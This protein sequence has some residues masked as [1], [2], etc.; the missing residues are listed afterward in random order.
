MSEFTALMFNFMIWYCMS[1][2][3]ILSGISGSNAFSPWHI[4]FVISFLATWHWDHVSLSWPIENWI[5][6]LVCPVWKILNAGICLNQCNYTCK[7]EQSTH[8]KNDEL[9]LHLYIQMAMG[10][11][12]WI[13]VL[14]Q[15]SQNCQDISLSF[16]TLKTLAKRYYPRGSK[17]EQGLQN[18]SC[19]YS[20]SPIW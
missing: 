5:P 8:Q 3:F 11:T 7:T 15:C 13:F 9:F 4:C 20:P 19:V 18:H 2:I 10:I 1:S 6:V 12:F 16:F 14:Y 17:N